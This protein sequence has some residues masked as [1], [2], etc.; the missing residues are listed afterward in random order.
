[1]ELIIQKRF[2]FVYFEFVNLFVGIV[3]ATVLS[4]F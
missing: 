3:A 2:F 1:M 4:A